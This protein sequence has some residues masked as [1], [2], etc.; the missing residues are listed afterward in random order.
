MKQDH[1][2]FKI[3]DY[4]RFT[5][6]PRTRAQYPN[7]EGFGIRVGKLYKIRKIKDGIYLYF[8]TNRGGFP[9]DDFTRAR[10][11]QRK[12]KGRRKCKSPGASR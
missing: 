9:W 10:A 11:P 3:G 12:K 6:L 1:C 8:G 5:P 7:I 2:P 4:V